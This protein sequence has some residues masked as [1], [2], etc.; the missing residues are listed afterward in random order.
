MEFCSYMPCKIRVCPMTSNHIRRTHAYIYIV[1]NN[2]LYK[3]RIICRA[4]N[5]ISVLS[6]CS[7]MFTVSNRCCSSLSSRTKYI[8][9]YYYRERCVFVLENEAAAGPPDERMRSRDLTAPPRTGPA[10]RASYDDDIGNR[11]SYYSVARWR[12]P[13][14]CVRLVV[15]F[16]LF[17]S[18]TSLAV[19]YSILIPV[20][21]NHNNNIIINRV[22]FKL[23]IYI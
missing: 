12:P 18:T 9:F 3:S 15:W 20:Y 17:F 4:T 21:H 5:V 6:P 19:V 2:N 16:L 23:K 13:I 8:L 22:V 7:E 1:Y 14:F 10:A 11:Y